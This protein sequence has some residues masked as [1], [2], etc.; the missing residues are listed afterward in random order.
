MPSA[1]ATVNLSTE[2]YGGPNWAPVTV[3]PRLST[4]TAGS[5]WVLV[6]PDGTT[7]I[8]AKL[9]VTGALNVSYSTINVI[10]AAASVAVGG[11]LVGIAISGAGAV[12]ENA[13]LTKTDAYIADSKVTSQG[14]DVSINAA[15]TSAITAT[16]VA[17][18]VAIGGGGYAGV[19]ASIGVAIAKQLHRLAGGRH[20]GKRRGSCLRPAL[21]ASAPAAT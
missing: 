13:I 7:Y 19:A 3:L 14:G 4:L 21:D 5:M 2:N 11:G 16:V 1:D 9:P 15:S 8:I 10:V 20:P 6:A 17:A 12:A 18:S